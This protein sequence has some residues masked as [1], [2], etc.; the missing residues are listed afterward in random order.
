M[1]LTFCYL[2]IKLPNFKLVN[3]KLPEWKLRVIH[4]FDIKIDSRKKPF[5]VLASPQTHFR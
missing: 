5:K 3:E 2:A 1:V 4:S